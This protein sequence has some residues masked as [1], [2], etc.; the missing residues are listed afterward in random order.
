MSELLG[1]FRQILNG[2]QTSAITTSPDGRRIID[3][4]PQL[5]KREFLK[6][7]G[8]L[9][10][11]AVATA[12]CAPDT[13]SAFGPAV[14]P[15]AA[16]AAPTAEPTKA[17][18]PTRGVAPTAVPKAT[19]PTQPAV[20]PT[21]AEVKKG[22]VQFVITGDILTGALKNTGVGT[23]PIAETTPIAAPTPS[24]NTE[25]PKT[26]LNV[27]ET[28]QTA[29]SNPPELKDY[30]NIATDSVAA[31]KFIFTELQMSALTGNLDISSSFPQLPKGLNI[32][33]LQLKSLENSYVFKGASTDNFT[34]KKDTHLMVVG[35]WGNR[36][37]IVCDDYTRSSDP[38]KYQLFSTFVPVDEL[39]ALL[40][41]NSA[42]I[43]QTEDKSGY[44]FSYAPNPTSG[45]KLPLPQIEEKLALDIASRAGGAFFVDHFTNPANQ[46]QE[47]NPFPVVP[48]VDKTLFPAGA[49]LANYQVSSDGHTVTALDK[50]KS[51]AVANYNPN[52]VNS[53]LNENVKAWE[54]KKYVPLEYSK[55]TW[56]QL[57]P[58]DQ[59]IIIDNWYKKLTLSNQAKEAGLVESTQSYLTMFAQS[60]TFTHDPEVTVTTNR[61]IKERGSLPWATDWEKQDY[62]R[63]F[64]TVKT[65]YTGPVTLAATNSRDLIVINPDYIVDPNV[66][67]SL[68]QQA[69][70]IIKNLEATCGLVKEGGGCSF[71]NNIRLKMNLPTNKKDAV[72]TYFDNNPGFIGVGEAITLP[73]N[74]SF[75]SWVKDNLSKISPIPT[76]Q[77]EIKKYADSAILSNKNG[78]LSGNV[79]FNEKKS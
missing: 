2:G 56:N 19:E 8:T 57:S 62:E 26:A 51:F 58:E 47:T 45:Y 59:K 78:I 10:L 33:R 55:E 43:K 67:K 60:K 18:E 39:D 6:L 48:H 4:H 38:K 63:G 32:P 70:A 44:E 72:K 34:I 14:K 65:I 50:G 73:L 3:G 11:V 25:Q 29:W 75:W 71:F 5:T 28:A 69:Q 42:N 46:A 15:A 9:C 66:Y 27:F 1:K 30:P 61:I 20:Q 53:P 13:R 23:G 41:Q 16:P 79:D 74:I 17:P 22:P 36:A 64:F 40:K 49:T 31:L 54:W 35:M 37:L 24:P 68:S 12:A 52:K 77:A 21:S 76:V 7:T